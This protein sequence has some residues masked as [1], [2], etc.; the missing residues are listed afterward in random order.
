MSKSRY[1]LNKGISEERGGEVRKSKT[2]TEQRGGVWED[3]CQNRK[4]GQTDRLTASEA[5][6]Q[7]QWLEG[8]KFPFW[9]VAG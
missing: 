9:G 2:G 6:N 1:F 3:S 8:S 5:L 4:E 7:Q